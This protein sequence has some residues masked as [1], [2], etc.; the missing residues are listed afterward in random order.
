VNQTCQTKSTFNKAC[1]KLVEPLLVPSS[2][3]ELHGLEC[4]STQKCSCVDS[5]N[6]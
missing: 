6:K 1:E 3:I 4:N 5:E 2:C